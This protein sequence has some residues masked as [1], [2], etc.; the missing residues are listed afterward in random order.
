MNAYMHFDKPSLIL[1]K[2]SRIFDIT[3]LNSISLGNNKLVVHYSTKC[4]G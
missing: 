1:L 3:Y 4:V 2:Y